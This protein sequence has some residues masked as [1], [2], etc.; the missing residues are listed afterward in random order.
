ME[1]PGLPVMWVGPLR[2]IAERREPCGPHVPSRCTSEFDV[3]VGEVH[4]LAIVASLHCCRLL[5]AE[6]LCALF[7]WVLGSWVLYVFLRHK[8]FLN[9]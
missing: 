9:R 8:L 4:S 1:D 3:F 2:S 6:F 7:P 5:S